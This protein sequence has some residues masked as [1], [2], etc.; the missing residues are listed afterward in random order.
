MEINKLLNGIDFK[1]ETDFKDAL[2]TGIAYDSRK[3]KKGDA[4]VCIS[5]F[6]TD[7]HNYIDAAIKNGAS[8]IVCEKDVTASV[9]YVVVK[10]CRKALAKM[11][12]N[13]YDNPTNKFRLIG[14]TGTNG[15]T[16]TTY[17]V[18]SVLEECGSLVGLIGTN[19]NMIG[20]KT[21]ESERTTPESLELQELFGGM[22]KAGADY[23]VMEV[24]SHSLELSRVAGCNFYVG[25]FTN[26]TRDHLD[27]HKTMENY[28][29]AK[30]KLFAV[31]EKAVINCDDEAGRIIC[32]SA[33]GSVLTYGI[34]N[35]TLKATDI[36]LLQDKVR[37]NV[38]SDDLF[39]PIEL[40]IP[41]E[42]SVY[43]CLCAIGIC[44][45]I[46]IPLKKIQSGIK[47]AKGISGRAEVV[48]HKNFTIVIDYAH[49]PDG[50]YNI[51]STMKKVS[52]G[53]VV[54]VFGCGGDRDRS[55]RPIMGKV[56]TE[57]SDFSVVTSDNPRTEEPKSI[58]DDI[59]AGI[60]DKN[61]YVSIE[62]RKEA[63]EYAIKTAQDNDIIILAGKGHE[64][65][66]EINGVKYDFNERDIVGEIIKKYNL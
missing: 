6:K 2:V 32:K 59:I 35:G 26:L 5:G 29:K 13:F 50:L 10:D 54:T 55:K 37:F 21:Y 65:Y 38:K 15:K 22:E 66:Q 60:C 52:K 39:F 49:T 30:E 64:T 33:E 44:L 41:G 23:V 16:T 48:Y 42:F 36:E 1:S 53:R 12:T 34:N 4:F 61:S 28:R 47:K 63:I 57:L 7:G 9:P 46:G 31:C 58:I 51:I 11:A 45:S 62:N 19:K 56:A 27:F 3:V 18:K 40:N 17:L 43:N 8:L 20:E 14:I 25:A 24:S